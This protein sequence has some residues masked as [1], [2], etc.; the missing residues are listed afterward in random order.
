MRD[1]SLPTLGTGTYR[2]RMY[3]YNAKG[4]SAAAATYVNFTVQ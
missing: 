1:T 2:M 3:A 4:K